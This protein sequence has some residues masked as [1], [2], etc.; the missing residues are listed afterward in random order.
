[1][2]RTARCAA[3]LLLIFVLPLKSLASELLVPVGEVIGLRLFCGSV[4]VAA[5]DDIL[6][7]EAKKSG[8]S[9]GDEILAVDGVPVEAAE[10]ILHAI[11]DRERVTLTVRRGS[12]KMRMELPVHATQDGPRLGISLREGICGIGTVTWYDPETGRFGALGHGVSDS[13]GTLAHMRGGNAYK[14]GVISVKKGTA[15]CPGQL[16]GSAE[17]QPFG[18]LIQNTPQGICAVSSVP[19]A[20]KALPTAEYEEIK[21][22]QARIL[23]TVTGNGPR[24][25]S[26]EIEKIY[27]QD[28]PDGRNFLLRVT[29]EELLKT[30]GGIVQGMSGSPIIQDGKL[31]GA[32]THVLVNDPTRGYGIFI[33]NMLEAAE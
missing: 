22:G 1:M 8:L 19:F 20:G 27:P 4:T 2:K 30:T 17:E 16:R 11:R 12:R 14:A 23:S 10:D 9:P 7:A 32:V 18:E 29:D 21:S 24:E 25:Y 31:V 33:E 13:S 26:V 28:R 15:G 5:L 6:G 3:V